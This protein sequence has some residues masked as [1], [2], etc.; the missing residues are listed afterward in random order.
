[1][2]GDFILVNCPVCKSR[3][4]ASRI[5]GE[6]LRCTSCGGQY[7]ISEVLCRT[8]DAVAVPGQRVTTID[9]ALQVFRERRIGSAPLAGVAKGTLIQLGG[10]EVFEDREWIEVITPEGITGYALYP[11]V[12]AHTTLDPAAR[13]IPP[14]ANRVNDARANRVRVLKVG[15][16][17]AILAG[18]AIW[19]LEKT[20]SRRQREAEPV[21]GRSAFLQMYKRAMTEGVDTLPISLAASDFPNDDGKARRWT[22]VFVTPS[23]RRTTT[24]T[25]TTAEGV[26]ETASWV[27]EG[28]PFSAGE[29]VIDSDEAVSAARTKAFEFRKRKPHL[30][31]VFLS[32]QDGFTRPVW[33]IDWG[34]QEEGY[35]AF[36]DA[37]TG[38]VQPSLAEVSWE[39][40]GG[41]GRCA[42]VA[43]SNV[44]LI[45]SAFV[46][47]AANAPLARVALERIPKALWAS[48]T[49]KPLTVFVVYKLDQI[50]VGTYTTS[51]EPAYRE[52]V[53]VA[54]FYWPSKQCVGNVTVQGGD[55][56]KS[57]PVVHEPG[58][59]SSV[60]LAAW[61]TGLGRKREFQSYGR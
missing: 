43:Q 36:V 17:V 23:R 45:G 28:K 10:S 55:P 15:A 11:S 22:A 5:E 18:L 47:D 30:A 34:E 44:S 24:Y 27:T 19:G 41:I 40:S 57:R 42:E 32:S 46:W 48:D 6:L 29:F 4:P 56:P 33:S 8:V 53:E 2:A 21:L 1:M 37:A 20:A 35:L 14:A 7:P 9:A 39:L 51:N 61:I 31:R 25:F 52:T 12:R 16:F 13:S 58:Y 60:E 38:A 50:Q 54:V 49:R 3:R 59:G 26:A